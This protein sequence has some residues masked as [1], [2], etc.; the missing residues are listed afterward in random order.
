[1]KRYILVSKKLGQN[2]EKTEM[3]VYVTLAKLPTK[4]KEDKGLYYPKK[5]DLLLSTALNK[6]NASFLD[7]ANA[8]EGCLVDVDFKVNEFTMKPTISS[9]TIVPG[10]N[11]FTAADL[12]L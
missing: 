10:T 12:Y 3:V 2:K 11:I 4:M 6:D 8:N 1:M 5:D 7:F 9:M